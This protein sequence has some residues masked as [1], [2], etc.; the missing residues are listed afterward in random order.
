MPAPNRHAAAAFQRRSIPRRIRSPAILSHAM[1]TL[2]RTGAPCSVSAPLN[3]A[4][5]PRAAS[6]ARRFSLTPCRR[7]AE[8]ER[9][10]AFQRR[11]TPCRSPRRSPQRFS[12]SRHADALPS[13]SALQR[14]PMPRR[15]PRA[16]SA[17]RRF[18]L[19]PCRCSA[20]PERL[21]AFQ[22]RSTP[23]RSP[24]A[25]SAAR[26]FSLSPCRCSAEP[27]RITARS[28]AFQRRPMPCR[29]PRAASAARS[30]FLSHAM[31][32]LRR[33]AAQ[34]SVSV[35]LNAMPF[36]RRIRSPPVLSHAM[37]MRRHSR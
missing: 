26:R 7:S 13:R 37:P 4:P 22:R 15:S 18:S 28:T 11:P 5:F 14:R 2:C 23:C 16:A 27:E 12:L 31:P 6:A 24:R 21:T 20:E 35:P 17:A 34:H 32:M 8:P 3:A 9:L 30:G 19:T 25:A 1:P 36:P 10:A 33:A 29:S